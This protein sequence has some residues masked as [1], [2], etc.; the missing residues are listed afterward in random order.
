MDTQSVTE[1]TP[2]EAGGLN[3]VIENHHITSNKDGHEE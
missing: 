1:Q 3:L 2:A